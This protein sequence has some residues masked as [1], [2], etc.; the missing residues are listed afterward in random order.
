MWA[1]TW[2]ESLAVSQRIDEMLP[3][4]RV[5]TVRYVLDE[6][7]PEGWGKDEDGQYR[8][9][10]GIPERRA[11]TY[12]FSSQVCPRW[13]AIVRAI[14]RPLGAAHVMKLWW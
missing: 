4:R 7:K 2:F 3:N 13:R 6:A 14:W 1:L 8:M 10:P 9:L 11:T 5:A 12:L